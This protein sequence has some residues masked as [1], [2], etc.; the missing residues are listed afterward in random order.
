MGAIEVSHLSKH[1]GD[2]VAVDD[3]SFE[4]EEGE[5][6]GYLGPNGAGKTTTIRALLGFQTPTA[7][8]ATLLG[9]DIAD[10]RAL[11]E[12]KARIGYLPATPS[13]DE[14]VTGE[15]YLDFHASLK[16][17]DRRDELL[18][19]FTP[20][21][22]RKIST[23]STGNKQMLGIVQTFMHDPDLVIMDE[24]TAGLDPIKQERFNEFLRAERDRGTTVLFS[25]HILGEVRRVCDRVGVIRNGTLVAL[26]DVGTLLE[27]G[28]KLVRVHTAD[29]L[30]AADLDFDGVVD[31]E[32]AGN[33]ARFTFTGDYNDLVALLA[34]YDV[35]DLDIE[36][37]PLEDVFMHF[38]GEEEDA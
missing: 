29:P 18:A 31:L 2:V 13:F 15:V 11:R 33:E 27:R 7:G 10:E 17:D 1:Y 3:L 35:V 30:D 16:G 36:E 37:P 23:Y 5:I 22:D 21:L 25:S 34:A 14:N 6:F 28:G 38:Y 12:A 20:P 19:M 24:P 4:V 32:R 26:E 9:H 8:G